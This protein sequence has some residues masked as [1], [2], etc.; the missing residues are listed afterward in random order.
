MDNQQE[1]SRFVEMS[2]LGGIIDGEG[3]ITLS[4]INR[5]NKTPLVKPKVSIVNTDEKIIN[6]IK[7]ILTKNNFA[8]WVS[9]YE[10]NK[11]WKKRYV[12]EI[13]GMGRIMKFLPEINSYL[14]GKKELGELVLQWCMDR[15]NKRILYTP[16]DLE[17]IK[18]VKSIHGHQDKIGKNLEILRDYMLN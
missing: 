5:T 12:I 6:K 13:S 4:I 17:I 2:W 8:F 1:S 18:K 3:T 10:G 14:V 15:Y 9:E 16:S 11:N 7:E